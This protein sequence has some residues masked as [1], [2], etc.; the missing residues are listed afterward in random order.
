M[1][2]FFLHKKS[3]DDFMTS[4]GYFSSSV[5]NTQPFVPSLSHSAF[6]NTFFQLFPPNWAC[7]V[8]VCLNVSTKDEQKVSQSFWF[9]HRFSL[10]SSL[11]GWVTL[12]L[13]DATAACQEQFYTGSQQE[14]LPAKG[15]DP[16][17]VLDL[18]AFTIDVNT[19]THT[20]FP[21]DT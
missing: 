13:M 12:C 5:Y 1:I 19:H 2:F 9:I 11:L 6:P 7:L 3:K 4:K 10:M 16:P 21:Q 18:S 17:L 20:I 15:T 14:W 8:I